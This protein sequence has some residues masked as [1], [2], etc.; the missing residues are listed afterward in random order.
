MIYGLVDLS[1]RE[2][3]YVSFYVKSYISTRVSIANSYEIN[4][5]SGHIVYCVP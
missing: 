2:R 5:M 4:A 3:S 1:M